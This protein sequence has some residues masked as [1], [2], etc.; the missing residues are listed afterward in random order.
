MMQMVCI[1]AQK[2][3]V[4]TIGPMGDVKV[5]S[6]FQVKVKLSF[7]FIVIDISVH[8]SDIQSSLFVCLH[9]NEININCNLNCLHYLFQHTIK[10]DESL[11]CSY[12]S[13]VLHN[14]N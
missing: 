9:Y 13:P 4:M 5:T 11:Q 2:P 14:F 6:L 8:F 10:V 12:N 7:L 1:R 3:L